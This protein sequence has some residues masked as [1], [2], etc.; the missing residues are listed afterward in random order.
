M[1][2][3]KNMKPTAITRFKLCLLAI[4]VVSALCLP[5]I[6]A[7]REPNDFFFNEQWYLQHI[8]APAAWDYS[9]G[10][11]TV[12]IAIIDS[13]VDLDHPDLRDNIWR[14]VNEIAGDGIDNDRNGY[15]DDVH[16][17]D[18]VSGDNDPNPEISDNYLV[19]GANHGTVSAGLA[20]AK[21]DNQ[22][23][24]VGVTWQVPIM[25]LR[26][27]DSNGLGDPLHVARAVDYAV[28]NGAK[29]I[30]LSF[31]GSSYNALLD[32][33]LRRA[34]DHGVFVVAAAGN[35]PEGQPATNLDVSP[36]YPVCFDR[37]S[38]VNY[39]Y[40]VAGTD[41]NDR[42][43]QF[44][45]YGASCVDISAPGE[46]IVSTQLHFPGH[47]DF[48]EPYGGYYN[49]TSV[50]A[51][52][53]S[54][55]VALMF[56]L[57]RNLTPR[58]VMNLLMETSE[59]ID[60]L[61]PEYFG[62]LGRG[63][64]QADQA[65]R[66]VLNLRSGAA[67]EPVTPT[68]VLAPPK[69][70]GQYVIAAPG[71]GRAPEV[72]LFTSDG[73]YVRSFNAYPESFRGGVSLAIGDFDGT[74]SNSI[75][76]G[77]LTGGGPHVRIFDINTRPIG[78]FF[79]YDPA[80][81]G[82]VEVDTADLDGDGI[83]EIITGAGPGGGPHVRMFDKRGLSVGGFFAFESYYRGGVDVAAGDLNA[84]GST[85]IVVAPGEGRSEV[86]VYNAKGQHLYSLLPFGPHYDRGYQVEMGDLNGDGETELVIRGYNA[87]GTVNTAVYNGAREYLGDGG[88]VPDLSVSAIGANQPQFTHRTAW[89]H[90]NEPLVTMTATSSRPAISF[91]AFESSFRGGVRAVLVE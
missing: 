25:A 53:V 61:N 27:L 60:S 65:V 29:V 62:R 52:L 7:A 19:L 63:R 41:Q 2:Y 90:L 74:D 16:G 18:F 38:S 1:A 36:H 14:N 20:A 31:V 11:E 8:G 28:A 71:A 54:G 87:D 3:F 70:Q 15:I 86:R 91:H 81:T 40:G 6:A 35:A 72:R 34:Y 89:G 42:K 79:A 32:Q 37:D 17:W 66:R 85:E 68:A 73:L 50:A 80:F 57:D 10:M 67:A 21:G 30:N 82:G 56:S 78:G 88:S 4:T 69:T 24:I 76:T 23:G 48:S 33:A 44:S 55:L 46:R 22:Q 49:G 51:P 75:V 43:A 26:A 59:D 12:P 45:N 83:D 77:A 47:N 84:D 5:D 13:G 39:V 58:Q 9:L 64:I